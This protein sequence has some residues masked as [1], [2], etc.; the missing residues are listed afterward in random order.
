MMNTNNVT[1]SYREILK[2]HDVSDL[3]KNSY[4]LHVSEVSRVQ[5]VFYYIY[6][7]FRV[8]FDIETYC[9]LVVCHSCSAKS[10]TV[11]TGCKIG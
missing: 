4:I 1:E 9:S 11:F 7:E 5:F 3:Q 8:L 2:C 6:F 10:G